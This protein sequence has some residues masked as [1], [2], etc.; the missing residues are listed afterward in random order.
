MDAEKF[1]CVDLIMRNRHLTSSRWETENFN[2]NKEGCQE[3]R[4]FNE[5]MDMSVGCVG[6]GFGVW[7]SGQK[8]GCVGF[9]AHRCVAKFLTYRI[10]REEF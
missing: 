5:N 2:K 8:H 7:C 1:Y 9:V 6:S 10:T 4:H 3:G